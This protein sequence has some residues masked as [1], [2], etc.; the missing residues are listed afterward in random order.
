MKAIAA[1]TASVPYNVLLFIALGPGPNGI[2]RAGVCE[3]EFIGMTLRCK[4]RTKSFHSRSKSG[5]SL[6]RYSIPI[7]GT[8]QSQWSIRKDHRYETCLGRQLDRASGP[9]LDQRR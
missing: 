2:L 3:E 9:C 4:D 7:E 6:S 8:N 1:D 5:Y